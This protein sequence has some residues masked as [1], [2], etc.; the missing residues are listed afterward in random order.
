ME[1]HNELCYAPKYERCGL[2]TDV[3]DG[4][5]GYVRGDFNAQEFDFS[6]QEKS[7]WWVVNWIDF[8][9]RKVHLDSNPLKRVN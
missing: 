5:P 4:Q 2:E 1:V 6:V 9:S 8:K 3:E 7:G